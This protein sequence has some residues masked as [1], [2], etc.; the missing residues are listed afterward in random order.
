MAIENHRFEISE[1]DFALAEEIF[2]H[3]KVSGQRPL[4]KRLLA[5]FV[6]NL[7]E[8]CLYL[9]NDKRQGWFEQFPII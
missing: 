4:D 7:L 9:H 8:L 2:S 1:S 6:L 3:Q 5:I